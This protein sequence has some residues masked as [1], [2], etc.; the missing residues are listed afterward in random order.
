MQFDENNKIPFVELTIFHKWIIIIIAN[1]NNGI[2][3][4]TPTVQ[5]YALFERGAII[6]V[7]IT[8]LN[9]N[10]VLELVKQILEFAKLIFERGYMG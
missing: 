3:N 8:Q 4:K 1:S 6:I 7:I 5:N 9:Y 10:T 2:D